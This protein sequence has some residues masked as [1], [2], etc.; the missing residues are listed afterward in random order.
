MEIKP[1][2][3]LLALKYWSLKQENQEYSVRG[4]AESIG[5][6]PGEVS[7]GAKRL[8]AKLKISRIFSTNSI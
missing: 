4:I 7:K 6:S 3:I 1:Q 8:L 2:D 5:I